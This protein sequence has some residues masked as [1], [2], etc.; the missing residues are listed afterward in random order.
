[1]TKKKFKIKNIKKIWMKDL[2]YPSLSGLC[3]KLKWPQ[4]QRHLLLK[5]RINVGICKNEVLDKLF[6]N[7]SQQ[8]QLRVNMAQT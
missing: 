7:I 6:D 4:D 5:R 2:K 1:M 8:G 3:L